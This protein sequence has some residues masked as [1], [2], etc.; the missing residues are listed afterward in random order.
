MRGMETNR[1]VSDLTVAVVGF[2][3]VGHRH[4]ENLARLGIT[5][6]IVVRRA[7]ERNAAFTPPT[8]TTVVDSHEAALAAE[9][10]LAVIS[11]PTRFHV[12][13]ASKYVEAGVPVLVEKPLSDRPHEATGLAESAR[14]RDVLA[15][16][17]YPLRYH[18]AYAAARRA[19]LDGAI[20]RPLYAKAWFETYLPDWHPWEDY[21]ESYAARPELGGGILPTLDHEI[22]FLNWCFGRPVSFSGVCHRSGALDAPI[23]DVAMLA[24]HYECGTAVRIDLSLCRKDHSRGFEIIGRHGTL[25]YT[26]R[27]GQL[28]QISS[29]EP[30]G[31]LL[32]QDQGDE[33]YAMYVEMLADVLRAVASESSIAPVPLECGLQALQVC[34]AVESSTPT[35]SPGPPHSAP[36]AT[37]AIRRLEHAVES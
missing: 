11:N 26:M 6:R 19:L 23:A 32:H 8:G 30:A 28:K 16:M 12:E 36:D 31:E 7:V 27:G 15:T 17:A 35:Q 18:T 33:V 10:D 5:R 22:D 9:P 37:P 14:E 20:G 3:S 2:G 4:F 34:A 29:D 24:G 13:T 25:R 21:R 1:P